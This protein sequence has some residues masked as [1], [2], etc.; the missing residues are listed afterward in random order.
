MHRI[1]F[2]AA[3][4]GG[5]AACVSASPF[6]APTG[7]L[8]GARLACDQRYPARIGNYLPHAQ[9]VNAAIESYALPAARH[10]ELLRIQEDIRASLAGR[11][12]RRQISL[13]AGRNKMNEADALVAEIERD[14]DRGNQA[15]AARRIKALD[16][17]VR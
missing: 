9:C 13:E 16:A 1:I 7:D 8:P 11:V 5:L 6:G 15:A 14:Q 4:C 3:I 2:C 12:D 17:M 10:P